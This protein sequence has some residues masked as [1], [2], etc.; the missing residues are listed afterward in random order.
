MPTLDL[1]DDDDL[2][3]IDAVRPI[4]DGVVRAVEPA[5]LY[6]V[7]VDSWFGDNW[8][9]FSNKL[10][11]LVGVQYRKTLRV[12]PFVPARVVS[13]RFF[14]R[15]A[16]QAHGHERTASKLHLEQTSAANAK[17][18]MSLVAPKAAVFWWSGSTRRNQR[19]ALMA[20][21][22]TPNGHV[23][24]YAAFK[25]TDDWKVAR[26]LCTTARE[27]SSYATVT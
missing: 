3:F 1:D 13:Q 4:I 9:G 10:R 22:P 6:V 18:L 27:L 16:N 2:G 8:L 24:W 25:N 14:R 19:G 23:G 21:L 12:P 5:E 7:K 17:R 15:E 26:A 20:Y 11:G